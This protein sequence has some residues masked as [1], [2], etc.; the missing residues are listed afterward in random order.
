MT[1]TSVFCELKMV[2]HLLAQMLNLLRSSL[3]THSNSASNII[4][5]IVIL[6]STCVSV[7]HRL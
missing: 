7:M 2:N 1:I 4:L 5:S 3:K 6:L